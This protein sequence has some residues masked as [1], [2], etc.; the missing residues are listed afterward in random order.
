M[1]IWLSLTIPLYHQIWY[2]YKLARIIQ[3]QQHVYIY[4]NIYKQHIVSLYLRPDEIAERVVMSFQ[5]LA[6]EL[7]V[8]DTLDHATLP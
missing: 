8:A 2:L 7:L 4:I 3:Q 1:E 6:P 5:E